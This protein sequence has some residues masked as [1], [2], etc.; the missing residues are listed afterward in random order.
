L[1]AIEAFC[2]LKKTPDSLAYIHSRISQEAQMPATYRMACLLFAITCWGSQH[3]AAQAPQGVRG[4]NVIILYADD[5]GWGD[6]GCYGHPKFKTPHI[7]RMAAEGVK[8]TNFQSIC[9]YCAPS[10]AGLLT[11]RYQFR[12]GMTR[13]PA[14]DAG[15]HTGGG[16]P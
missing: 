12:S 7:D 2:G 5:L 10:R 14:P 8:L 3:A 9:P 6:L 15:S 16:L 11:G 13:N 1:F 4:T